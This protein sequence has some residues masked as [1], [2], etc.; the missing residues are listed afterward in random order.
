M[1]RLA[2]NIS[3]E[4]IFAKMGIHVDTLNVAQPEYYKTLSALLPQLP[5]SAWKNK[6]RYDYISDKAPALSKVFR[7][8]DF[9]FDQLFSGAQKQKERWKTMVQMSDRRLKKM[10]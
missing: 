4:N 7:A 3:W 5:I 1:Q 8:E 2:P 10:W 6:V 9:K